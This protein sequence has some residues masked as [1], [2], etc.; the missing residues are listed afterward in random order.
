MLGAHGFGHRRV[1]RA[2]EGDA[3]SEPE[4]VAVLVGEAQHLV[5][6]APR[7]LGATGEAEDRVADLPDD[8]VEA[9]DGRIDPLA[10]RSGRGCSRRLERHAD[11]E[12][13]LDDRVVQV[14]RDPLVL[15]DDPETLE[16]GA[17]LAELD[18]RSGG[19]GE[20]LGERDVERLEGG[21]TLTRPSTSV[22]RC[23]SSA[24][25]GT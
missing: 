1:D 19:A 18:G 3:G 22:P 12:E 5:A 16:L 9:V 15:G 20:H 4:L 10:E 11:R 8:A 17:H 24:M 2:V 14:S 13:L 6:Q 23:R 21:R 25:S 7:R